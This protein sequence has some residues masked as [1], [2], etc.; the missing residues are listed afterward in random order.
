MCTIRRCWWYVGFLLPSG[1]GTKI[2]RVLSLSVVS[3]SPINTF[4]SHRH[5]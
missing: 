2:L 1:T 5:I 4:Q 3:V